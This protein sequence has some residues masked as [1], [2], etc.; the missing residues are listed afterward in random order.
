[1]DQVLP[2][3]APSVMTYAQ[4]HREMLRE[5]V[6][7]AEDSV[8]EAMHL[9]AQSRLP[10]VPNISSEA[11]FWYNLPPVRDVS[12]RAYLK[13]GDL[14]K[15][16]AAYS[17]ILSYDPEGTDR[18]LQLPKYHYAL[19][20]LCEGRELREKAIAEYKSFLIFWKDADPDL[21]EVKD[22]VTSLK[23]LTRNSNQPANRSDGR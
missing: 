13:K 20:K 4:Y 23:N 14:D 15:A 19:A 22:A 2:E 3:V 16:V 17:A 8:E 18:R 6:L 5:E 7:L 11:M 1:M 12:A 21:R 10:V 9:V